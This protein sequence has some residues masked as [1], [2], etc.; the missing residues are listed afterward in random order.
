[1]PYI[2]GVQP[3]VQR[4]NPAHRAM[5]FGKQG[6]LQSWKFGNGEA[7]AAL[8]VTASRTV[9]INAAAALSPPHFQTHREPCGPD[10]IAPLDSFHL[11]TK[12]VCQAQPR[13]SMWTYHLPLIQPT[14]P[15]C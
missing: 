5:S 4:L 6:S 9:A 11:W 2:S 3:L 7:M 12:P 14:R 1:M 15:E 8:I 10:G 13:S